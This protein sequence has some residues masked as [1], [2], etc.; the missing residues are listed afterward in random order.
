[1]KFRSLLRVPT[2][3]FLADDDPSFRFLLRETLPDEDIEIV[4]E[5]EDH[6]ELVGAVRE[7]KPDVVLLDQ[8]CDVQTV[9]QLRIAA[10]FARVVILSGHQPEDGDRR[11]AAVADGYVV[12]GAGLEELRAAVRCG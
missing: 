2:R 7:A 8:L 11:L 3:V 10:P 6:V 1:M 12:K 9:L 5:A 4:G